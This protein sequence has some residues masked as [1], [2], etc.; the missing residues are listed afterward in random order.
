MG[1]I[2]NSAKFRTM[3]S[4]PSVSQNCFFTS[5]QQQKNKKEVSH[6]KRDKQCQLREKVGS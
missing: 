4:F 5:A 6:R 3:P 2:E 1:F